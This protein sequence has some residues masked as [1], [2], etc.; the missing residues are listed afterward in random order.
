MVHVSVAVGVLGVGMLIPGPIDAAFATVGLLLFKH[1]A[2]AAAGLAL[3]N[4][5]A[6]GVIALGASGILNEVA[7]R[8]DLRRQIDDSI[9]S[10]GYC[11]PDDRLWYC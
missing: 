7:H 8:T 3:Y 9:M 5:L 10:S 4:L 1:P 11:D 6:V 2:G